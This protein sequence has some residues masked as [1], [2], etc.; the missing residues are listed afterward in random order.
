MELYELLVVR[1]ICAMFL[2]E[3]NEFC[4]HLH[5]FRAVLDLELFVV[6]EKFYN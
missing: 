6:I 2:T 5:Q 4:D 3:I 1:D